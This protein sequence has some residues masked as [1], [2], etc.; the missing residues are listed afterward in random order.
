MKSIIYNDL[1]EIY[2]RECNWKELEGKTFLLTGAYGM[3][4]SYMIYMLVYLRTEKNVCLRIIAQGRSRKKFEKRFGE[5]ATY[6]FVSFIEN[7]LEQRFMIDEHID[8][9][10]HAASLAS[11]QFYEVCPVDVLAPN[12][13][14]SYNLLCLAVEKNVSGFLFFSSGDIYGAV[15]DRKYIGESDYGIMDTLDIHNCYSESK[16]M[17]ETICRAFLQQY[18]VPVKIVRIW[19]TYAPTMDIENDPRVF[20]S[21]VKN[22]TERQNIIMKSD[23]GGKRTFCY[24]TDAVSGFFKVLLHGE[25]GAAYNICNSG[26]YVSIRELA[27]KLVNM[28]PE[29]KLQ[30]ICQQRD[31]SEHYTENVLLKGKDAVP[32]DEKLRT[33]GWKP[34]VDI[35]EGFR[36]V[37]SYIE[38][39]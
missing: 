28:Y 29:R 15:P 12:V 9:I 27:M 8:Y 4:A 33:L 3:L 23:G 32:S 6:E 17:G 37:I 39:T 5:I 14:G 10:V 1:E 2:A 13:L 31:K 38:E 11:P 24:I 25:I 36:R 30:L 26:Q 18:Q 7:D 20:S 21:F 22:I 35:E 34:E 16:R 19:H